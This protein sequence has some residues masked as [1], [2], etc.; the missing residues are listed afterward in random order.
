MDNHS[1]DL[2][3]HGKCHN[4]GKHADGE[5][6]K[7]CCGNHEK[8]SANDHTNENHKGNH[9]TTAPDK[10]KEIIESSEQYKELKD[11]L[12]RAL[13]ESE[14]LRKR[15]EKEKEDLLRYSAHKFAF[16]MLSVADNLQRAIDSI[17]PSEQ[18]TKIREGIEMTYK[19]VIGTFKKHNIEEIEANPGDKFDSSKHQAVMEEASDKFEKG[20]IVRVMQHGYMIHDRLLRPVVVTVAK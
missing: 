15:F 12:L 2:D 5:H 14:N 6:K 10:I 13:A 8:H 3:K 17:E 7:C 20:S 1:N 19:Q 11:A 4:S 16:D 9:D 18:G